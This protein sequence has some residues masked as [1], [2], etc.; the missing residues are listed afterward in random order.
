[1]V[2][3]VPASRSLDE[4]HRSHPASEFPIE[5]SRH[6]G[7]ALGTLHRVFRQP[8]LEEVPELSWLSGP[9]PWAMQSHCPPPDILSHLSLAGLR[10]IGILQREP[11]LSDRIDQAARSWQ[12]D[13]VIHGDVKSDNILVHQAAGPPAAVELTLVDWELVQV[14]D[15]AWD[16][17]G[18]LHDYLVFWTGSMPLE[19]APAIDLMLK[20]ARYPL[21][22][23]RPAIRALWSGYRSSAGLT[24]V[25]E[26]RLLRR[27][28]VD[29]AI[30]LIQS[31][32]ERAAEQQE[33]SGQA[34]LMLQISANLVAE[35][36][37]GQRALFGLPTESAP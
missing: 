17:G 6:L 16:L 3:L 2:D 37:L 33:L 15:A 32:Q 13:T 8:G 30:R 29:S 18:A 26:A 19:S 35:P 27:A 11:G 34:V 36:A 20:R 24:P 25:E 28:V 14:G 12:P 9:I 10:L 4:Y 31:A 5:A 7:E 1:V 21:E 22:V 23:L